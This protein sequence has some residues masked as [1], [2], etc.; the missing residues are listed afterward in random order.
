MRPRHPQEL[1]CLEQGEDFC[2]DVLIV[3]HSLGLI[4]DAVTETTAPS[5]AALEEDATQLALGMRG[6]EPSNMN[7]AK[8][9]SALRAKASLISEPPN[10]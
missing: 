2:G 7:L 9:G 5:C 6:S 3:L 10:C 4:L 1:G 8:G